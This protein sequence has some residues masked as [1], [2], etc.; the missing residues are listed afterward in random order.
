M[1]RIL[2]LLFAFVAFASVSVADFNDTPSTDLMARAFTE[3]VIADSALIDGADDLTTG[4]L[5][6]DFDIASS[7]SITLVPADFDAIPPGVRTVAFELYD[8]DAGDDISGTI[9]VTGYNQWNQRLTETITFEEGDTFAITR[10]AFLLISSITLDLAGT[11]TDDV[12]NAS[13]AGFGFRSR[14]TTSGIRQAN[15][16][17]G[18]TTYTRV[19]SYTW[20]PTFST[21]TAF[22]SALT[23][24]DEIELIGYQDNYQRPSGGIYNTS[25][26]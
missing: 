20:S 17:D 8:H 1:K 11:D 2:A 16:K 15:I 26:D 9:A 14:A 25:I 18:A 23:E 12:L 6:A 13:P 24:G 19:T 3:R 5:L 22:G 10:N 7:P 21:I 4:T